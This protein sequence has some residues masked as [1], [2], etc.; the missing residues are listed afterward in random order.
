MQDLIQLI[1]LI[2]VSLKIYQFYNEMYNKSDRTFR[3]KLATLKENKLVEIR[4]MKELT[5]ETSPRIH[6]KKS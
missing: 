3:R 6:F 5:G 4:D 1:K 2:M